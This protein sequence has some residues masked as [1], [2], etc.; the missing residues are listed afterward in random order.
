MD[1]AEMSIGPEGAAATSNTKHKNCNILRWRRM[2]FGLA[3]AEYGLRSLEAASQCL[4]VHECTLET[5]TQR[6][7]NTRA[8]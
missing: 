8:H 5:T 4:A 3:V 2:A 1:N 6:T 7:R